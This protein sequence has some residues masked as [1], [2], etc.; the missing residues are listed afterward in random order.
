MPYVKPCRNPHCPGYQ[1][2]P[3]HPAPV[4][5]AG[6]QPMGPG[7]PVLRASILARD[8]WTCQLCGGRATD[9][10][11]IVPRSAGGTDDPANLRSLCGP[12]HHRATGQLN[13]LR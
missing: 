6:S 8:G 10:D 2:C 13:R 7:W 9:V 11:H 12:C 1:P 3:A 4:P 5:F